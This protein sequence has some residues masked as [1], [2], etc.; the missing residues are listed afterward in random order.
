MTAV[1]KFLD[2]HVSHQAVFQ[3]T[4]RLTEGVSNSR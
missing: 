4:Y 1:I 2:V 3:W